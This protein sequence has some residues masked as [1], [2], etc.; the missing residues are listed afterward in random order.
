MTIERVIEIEIAPGVVEV[1]MRE[2]WYRTSADGGVTWS[3]EQQACHRCKRATTTR[4]VSRRPTASY[5]SSGSSNRTGNADLWYKTRGNGGATWSADT[6]LTTSS[7]DDYA[8]TITQAADGRLVVVWNRGDGVLCAAEQHGRRR[9]LVG[10][11]ADRRVLP[12]GPQPGGGRRGPVAGL[13]RGCGHL[14]SHQ[15]ESG[16]ELVGCDALHALRGKRWRRDAGGVGVRRAGPR[17]ALHPQRQ[18][19]IWFG[20]PGEPMTP[21]RHTSNGSSTGRNATWTAMTTI[22]FRAR[23][24]MRREW[25]A[26]I[27]SGR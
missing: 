17:L 13:R 10:R 9:D 21:D 18:Q 19:D 16:C 3:A 26:S 5:G 11:E 25:P 20:N 14:V 1:V 23:A 7:A 24:W 8:P 4:H 27:W 12:Q 22:T 2:I 6:R 15:R